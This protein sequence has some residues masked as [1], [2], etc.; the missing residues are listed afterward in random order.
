[1]K[2]TFIVFWIGTGLWTMRL[3]F[4][5]ST[6]AGTGA[7]P[8]RPAVAESEI[9]AP[10]EPG[11]PM[12]SGRAAARQ[13]QRLFRESRY[14]EAAR[15]YRHAADTAENSDVRQTYAYNAAVALARAGDTDEAA[16]LLRQLAFQDSA[17]DPNVDA[18]LG[19]A[20]V[21]SA[22]SPDIPAA[23][24][25]A[26]RARLLREAADAFRRAARAQPGDETALTNLGTVLDAW[27]EAETEANIARL[28]EEH[29]DADAANLLGTLLSE[30]RD[31]VAETA[32][33]MTNATPTRIAAL[34]ALAQRQK[35]NTDLWIPLKQKLAAELARQAEQD[36]V[37]KE[38]LARFPLRI[39]QTQAAMREAAS[40]L[41]DLDPGG[42]DAVR[43]SETSAYPLWK[44]IAPFDAVLQQDIWF[45]TNAIAR[46]TRHLNRAPDAGPSL[47]Y[48]DEALDLTRLFIDRFQRAV[49][50]P[51]AALPDRPPQPD[52]AIDPE[53]RDK[54]LALAAETLG[55]Q[56]E[57]LDRLAAEQRANALPL[58]QRAHALLKEIE[59]LLPK[60]DQDEPQDSPEPPDQDQD[61]EPDPKPGDPSDETPAEKDEAKDP[62]EPEEKKD[63]PPQDIQRMLERALQRE[64][65]FEAEK[66]RRQTVPASPWERDW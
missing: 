21:R 27:P 8:R 35:A 15:L 20:L 10:A 24:N 28:L 43:A 46:T 47:P 63:E 4:G 57:A 16:R 60:Q 59:D 9:A 5:D 41:R 53:T 65:E 11:R 44:A 62:E 3:A 38:N 6:E 39:E 32:Q 37:L 58:Q 7:P 23:T 52:S 50:P 51:D 29:R 12:P 40:R 61:D 30:Q 26:Q 48:Q 19:A 31:I 42:Y 54:I 25:L 45:Q 49:P 22:P 36:P 64:K 17:D 1:M 34:E 56:Q 13:A 14:I 55:V 33:A 2:K 18:A 66:R